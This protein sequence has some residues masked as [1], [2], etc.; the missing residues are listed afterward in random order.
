MKTFV[1]AAASAALAFLATWVLAPRPQP[2]R[3]LPNWFELPGVPLAVDDLLVDDW[4]QVNEI[5]HRST[6]RSYDSPDLN[7]YSRL[8]DTAAPEVEARRFRIAWL[9]RA[10]RGVGAAGA[11]ETVEVRTLLPL[12]LIYSR[13]GGYRPERFARYEIVRPDKIE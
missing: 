4:G 11:V 5:L 1:A 3:L 7:L 9:P 8:K 6:R 2:E 12:T 13:S 10:G